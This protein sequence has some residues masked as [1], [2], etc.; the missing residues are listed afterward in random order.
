MAGAFLRARALSKS[1]RGLRAVSDVSFDVP[2]GAIHA[3]IGPNGAGKTTTFNIVAGV[4]A[5]DAGGVTLDGVELVGK[6]PEDIC[7]AGVGRTFQI[8]ATF[9]S[10]TLAENVQMALMSQ[11]R[12]LW[13]APYWAARRRR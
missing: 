7:R 13:P 3:L 1:F 12:Q 8:A 2:A 9:A 6:R 5:P 11:A 10:M 4:F